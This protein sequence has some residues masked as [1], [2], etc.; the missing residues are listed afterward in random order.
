MVFALF[1][2]LQDAS[3]ALRRVLHGTGGIELHEQAKDMM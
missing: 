3:S 2:P 1:R